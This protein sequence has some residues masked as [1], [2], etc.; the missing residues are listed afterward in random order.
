M[1][2]KKYFN[3]QKSKYLRATV[4]DIAVGSVLKI[5]YKLNSE[6]IDSIQIMSMAQPGG[7][8]PTAA[9]TV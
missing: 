1:P 5:T 8:Q 3:I 2:S 6:E 9:V 7:T 4:A